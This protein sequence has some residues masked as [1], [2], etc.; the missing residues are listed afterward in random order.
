MPVRD[1]SWL[2]PA[3]TP[4]TSSTDLR[5]A[6]PA[7]GPRLVPDQRTAVFGAQDVVLSDIEYRVL[8]LLVLHPGVMLTREEVAVHAWGES[9]RSPDKV[10]STIKRI[11]H[12]LRAAGVDPDQLVTIHALGY[13]WDP[14]DD[15]TAIASESLRTG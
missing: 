7:R 13:R 9:L 12:R 3:F 6:G 4:V 14:S 2:R 10:T 15:D 1:R 5:D 8:E 11:R